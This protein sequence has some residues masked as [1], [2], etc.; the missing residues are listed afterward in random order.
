MTYCVAISVNAGMVFCSDSRTNAGVDQVSTYSKMFRF[1]EFGADR[2][3][4][5]LTAG[6]LATTQA[7]MAQMKKDIRAGAEISLATVSSIG[8]AADYLGEVSRMQQDKHAGNAAFQ[9]SFI[10]GGQIAGSEHRIV[11]VYPEG[12]HIT[13]SKDTPYLQIGESKYGK[14]IL[15]RI[16]TLETTLETAS[17]CALVSMDSTMRS[18]LT[19]GPPIELMIYESGSFRF[20]PYYRYEEDSDFL[21]NLKKSWDNK[22]KEAFHK[23]PPLQLDYG[24]NS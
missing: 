14:P 3:F 17:L 21:R 23:L 13:S 24:S 10:L 5:V 22:L 11:M 20:A 16:L 12:N 15:D 6:N 19:V 4:V 7:T 9:A 18:N 2:Q 1:E 8:E